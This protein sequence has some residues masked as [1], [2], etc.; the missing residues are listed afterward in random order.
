MINLRRGER[1]AGSDVFPFQIGEISQDCLLA[2]TG[3]EQV[4]HILHPDPHAS[5]AGSSATKFRVESDPAHE[6]DDTSRKRRM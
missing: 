1:Q 2:L 5:D 6:G 4:E 3:G